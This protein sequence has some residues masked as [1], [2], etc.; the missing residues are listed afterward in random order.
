MGRSDM[1][2]KNYKKIESPI[3][4]HITFS[5]ES[6]TFSYWDGEKEVSLDKLELVMLDRRSSVSGWSEAIGGR[7]FSNYFTSNKDH[8][9]VRASNK[10]IL[11]GT[12]EAD[13]D[14]IKEAG[15]EYQV[16]IFAL[17]DIGG[18]WVPVK[19]ALSK[20]ALAAWSSF[21]SEQKIWDLYGSLI[22]VQR[23]EQQKKGRVTYYTPTFT[24]EPLTEELS[25][26]ATAFHRDILKPYL[27]PNRTKETV[28]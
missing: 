18:Q 16:N 17:A 26:V 13:K 14:R 6:G 12:W 23:G 10:D 9:N 8:I 11:S 3:K 22:T 21:S 24:M 19:L 25:E 15:G 4:Y 20:S 2:T 7:I 27:E 5:G 1:N 28:A